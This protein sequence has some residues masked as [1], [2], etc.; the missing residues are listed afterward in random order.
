MAVVLHNDLE[1][2]IAHLKKQLIE[3]LWTQGAGLASAAANGTAFYYSDDIMPF[4]GFL[5]S[6]M[7]SA[8]YLE[9]TLLETRCSLGFNGIYLKKFKKVKMLKELEMVISDNYEEK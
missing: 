2:R 8:V 5:V 4:A 1:K 3:E 6:L 9:S 7:L